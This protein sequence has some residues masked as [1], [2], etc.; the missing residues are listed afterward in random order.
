MLSTSSFRR[1]WK[2]A[3][4]DAGLPDDLKVHEL[5]DTAASL[6]VSPGASIKAVQRQ[7]GHATAAMT[8][9]VYASLFEEELAARME[10]KYSP[11]ARQTHEKDPHPRPPKPDLPPAKPLVVPT[12][13]GWD[14]NPHALA[15][16]GF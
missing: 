6:M 7:L 5:R 1:V 9:D 12:C 16:S 8:L 14:S 4:A 3:V 15:G 2:R 10:A 11:T 13:P